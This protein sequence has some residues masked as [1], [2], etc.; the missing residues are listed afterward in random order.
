MTSATATSGGT[1]CAAASEATSR[2][3]ASVECASQVKIAA[4]QRR[5]DRLA[6][7]TAEHGREGHRSAQRRRRQGD[8]LQAEQH[9][10]ETERDARDVAAVLVARA[11]EPEHAS[12]DRGIGKPAEIEGQD[13]R[14]HGRAEIRAQHDRERRRGADQ[15]ATREGRHDQGRRGAGLHEGGDAEAGGEGAQ[16]VARARRDHAPDM[17]AKSAGDAGADH[18]YAPKEEGDAADQ[19]YEDLGAVHDLKRVMIGSRLAARPEL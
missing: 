12:S 10:P 15:R 3:M 5:D 7:E 19:R 9:Q 8:Q 6:G 1:S 17:R 11:H 14:G 2:T 4:D 13:L 16:A 18:A